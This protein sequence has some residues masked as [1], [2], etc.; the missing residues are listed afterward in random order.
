MAS[1]LV[2]GGLKP[3][4]FKKK[5][6]AKKK[7]R[8]TKP[9]IDLLAL[10]LPTKRNEPERD[11]RRYSFLL[12]GREGIGKT[13]YLSTFPGMLFITS[14]PGAKGLRIFEWNKENGGTT[15]WP[16]FLRAVEVLE[17]DPGFY[18]NIAID[19]VDRL[20]QLCV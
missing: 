4:K 6:K 8:S 10:A 14:E 15:S 20:H 18:K 11:L 5:K 13:T 12:Y 7:V 17:T 1:T 9:G 16:I 2:T 19:T 3:S